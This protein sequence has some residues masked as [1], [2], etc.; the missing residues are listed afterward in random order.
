MARKVISGLIQ[1]SNALN[2]ENASVE[3]VR[4]AMMEEHRP[5]RSQRPR[6]FAPT[7]LAPGP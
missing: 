1:V 7:Y 5:V 4:D 3:K 2:D 6:I